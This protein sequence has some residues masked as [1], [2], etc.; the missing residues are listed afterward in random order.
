MF[1]SGRSRLLHHSLSGSHHGLLRSYFSMADAKKHGSILFPILSVGIGSAAIILYLIQQDKAFEIEDDVGTH[2]N[3]CVITTDQIIKVDDKVTVGRSQGR[4]VWTNNVSN[5]SNVFYHKKVYSREKLFNELVLCGLLHELYRDTDTPFPK[6][7]VLER[8]AGAG[9]KYYS[10][11]S[12]DVGGTTQN[13]NL[14]A[15]L[16]QSGVV[17]DMA[18]LKNFGVMVAFNRLF[19]NSDCNLKNFVLRQQAAGNY[20]YG[21]DFE[22][23]FMREAALLTSARDVLSTI[24]EL[25]EPSMAIP[26]FQLNS[27]TATL[28]KKVLIDAV[29]QELE[30]LAVLDFYQKIADLSSD[31][32]EAVVSGYS[33]LMLPDEKAYYI[34]KIQ[35]SQQLVRSHLNSLKE[36]AQQ[37][38]VLTKQ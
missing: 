7:F 14:A 33:G 22:Y 3:V 17:I 2:S 23:A 25:K 1:R 28:S 12:E 15:Y 13:I 36:P 38:R 27:S 4:I 21:I 5:T 18:N 16:K 26:S 30:N 35:S 37:S 9:T 8:A 31:R 34:E 19:G 11:M 20:L 32:I 24:V 29:H 10:F 6:V